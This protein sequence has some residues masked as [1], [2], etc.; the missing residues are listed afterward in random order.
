M[1]QLGQ[2][3]STHVNE[4]PEITLTSWTQFQDY[5]QKE[6]YSL[7]HFVWRGQ[8]DSNWRL[9]SG[10]DRYVQKSA[11]SSATIAAR[12][13][14]RFKQASRGRRGESP[15]SPNNENEWWAL[16]QH[17]AMLTPL[18]DWTESPFV[19]LYFAFEKDQKPVSQKRAVWALSTDLT[20][21]SESESSHES[22]KR[23]LTKRSRGELEY[24]RPLQDDNSRLVNQ[25]GLFTKVPAG[26]TV[27]SWIRENAVITPGDVA[28]TK[29]VIPE[30]GREDCL[31]LLNR[32][33]INHL[34]LFPDLYGAGKHCNNVLQIEKY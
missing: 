20:S 26:T 28:L 1:M 6:P 24:I 32:M 15:N 17:N 14:E 12:H 25:A 13:L 31:R 2:S 19:A 29:F 10:L 11:D 30:E 23:S 7:P 16:A 22:D 21:R 8:R 4:T 33:N 3:A 9:E 18:L 5:V 27:E 34:S